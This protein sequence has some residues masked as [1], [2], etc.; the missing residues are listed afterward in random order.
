MKKPILFTLFLVFALTPTLGATRVIDNPAYAVKNSG[1]VNIV[2]IELSNTATRVHIKTTFLPKWWVKFQ[3][4]TFIQ[5]EDS[6]EKLIA[7]GIENGEFDK[8]LFMPASGDSLFVLIFPPLDKSVK[9]INYGEDQKTIVFG[10]SLEKRNVG[11]ERPGKEVPAD[12]RAW[13]DKELENAMV[14]EALPD[15]TSDRFFTSQPARLVGYIKGYDT[16]LGFS[17]GII[18]ANNIITHEDYPVALNIYPDGRFE[19]DIPMLYPTSFYCLINNKPIN[20]YMEPGHTLTMILDWE[21]FLIADRLRNIQYK[22][23]SIEFKGALSDINHELLKT[24]FKMDNW[25]KIEKMRKTLKP[26]DYKLYERQAFDERL[27]YISQKS[28]AYSLSPKTIALLTNEALLIYGT[29]LLEYVMYRM[30]YLQNEPDNEM[31]K[32]PLPDDYYDF[33]LKMPLNDQALIASNNISVFINR[34]EYCRPFSAISSQ[35]LVTP[36]KTFIQYLEEDHQDKLT[37]EDKQMKGIEEN[38]KRIK[39]DN[40]KLKFYEEHKEIFE[41]FN[42]KYKA[43]IIMYH[44]K[45]VEPQSKAQRKEQEIKGIQLRDSVFSTVLHLSKPSL[46]FDVTKVRRLKYIFKNLPLKQDAEEIL[47]ATLKDIKHPVLIYEADKVFYQTYPE[48]NITTYDLPETKGGVFFREM[49]AP[50]KGKYIVVDFWESSC[51][52]CIAGIKQSKPLREKLKD[53]NSI[54][55]LFIC[56]EDTPE[57]T[58]K[59]YVEEQGLENSHRLTKDQFIRMRELF[60]FNGIPHFE[61]VDREGKMMTKGLDM[62]N[63]ESSLGNLLREENKPLSK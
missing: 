4:T 7:T 45:Y 43:E 35:F 58:Y 38:L 42:Q 28:T 12:V 26:E 17:A 61:Y 54:A 30:M 48:N 41:A 53:D 49:I 19:A 59:Q 22:F 33:L 2:K 37:E 31:L 34:F 11:K 56:S 20:L 18:Y 1:I 5:P 46:I 15:Y 16:R 50:F 27:E 13:L 21:E 63:L 6:D 14:K 10:I 9:T 36:E 47:S 44:K 40:E 60:K 39:N 62:Y 57:V 52:P 32:L 24:E 29:S 55:F 51:G 25:K 23:K 8:E 3:K